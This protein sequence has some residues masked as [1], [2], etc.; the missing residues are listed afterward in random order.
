MLLTVMIGIMIGTGTPALAQ[1]TSLGQD[2]VKDVF[3]DLASIH[4]AGSMVKIW[5]LSDFKVEQ[6]IDGEKFLSEK[7]QHAANC[8]ENQITPLS[9]AAFREN[10]GNGF[11][12]FSDN[13]ELRWVSVSPGSFGEIILKIACGKIQ[14]S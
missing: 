11:V 12:V 8:R 3:V 2:K 7:A 1:W 4:R 13:V 6:E 10:M 9:I 14:P 5:S